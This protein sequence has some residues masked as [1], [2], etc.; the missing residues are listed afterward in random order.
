V[1]IEAAIEL[2]AVLARGNVAFK[3]MVDARDLA[4]LEAAFADLAKEVRA[5][6]DPFF[7]PYAAALEKRGTEL[8]KR[9]ENELR[10]LDA[11]SKVVVTA[12]VV[13]HRPQSKNRAIVHWD[14]QPRIYEESD[15]L[16]DRN[17]RR[18]DFVVVKI[19]EGLVLFKLEETE[20]T[21]ELKQ[22][23]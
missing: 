8:R 12:I 16:R 14:G 11:K 6:K 15:N 4:A 10:V 23:R 3:A 5:L 20:F 21:V 2:K 19:Q 22:P 17:D 9:R 7:Q 13:D 1:R 18:T